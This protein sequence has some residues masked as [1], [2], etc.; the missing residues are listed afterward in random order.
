M[1]DWNLAVNVTVTGLVLV[2]AM[3]LLLVFILNIFGWISVALKNASDKK[4][5]KA[6]EDAL[7]AMATIGNID[8]T[9]SDSDDLVNTGTSDGEL[10][11]VISAAVAAMYA[12]STK[13]PVI[14]AIKKSSG[15][16]SAWANAG[17]SDNTRVF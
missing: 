16:R 12:G 3:L 10:V 7:A 17:I 2:F 9:G 11:A 5:A 4:A 15:R 6:R 13:K 14:K 1:V 8:Q